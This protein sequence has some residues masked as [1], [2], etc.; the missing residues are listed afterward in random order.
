MNFFVKEMLIVC[1]LLFFNLSNVIAEDEKN[2]AENPVRTP[3]KAMEM[4]KE[5]SSSAKE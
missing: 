3:E 5:D 2:W 1:C 4:L